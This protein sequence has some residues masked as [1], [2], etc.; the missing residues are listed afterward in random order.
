MHASI[1]TLIRKLESMYGARAELV[2]RIP[3]QTKRQRPSD[4]EVL[5]FALFGHPEAS[6]CYAWEQDG[7]VITV[8]GGTTQAP[9]PADVIREA[10]LVAER[11]STRRRSIEGH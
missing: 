11:S 9:S 7:R 3:L 1:S 6:C 8:L 5:V 10:E 4:R 2:S